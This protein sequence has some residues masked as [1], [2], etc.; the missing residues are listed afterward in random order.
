MRPTLALTVF[1][2]TL[3]LAACNTTE[4]VGKDIKSAG[5]AIEKTAQDAKK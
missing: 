4:G 5:G 1:L 2:A 3:T